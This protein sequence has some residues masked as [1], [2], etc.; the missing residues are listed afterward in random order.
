MLNYPRAASRGDE[1]LGVFLLS[2]WNGRVKA[3][4]MGGEVEAVDH[5][6]VVCVCGGGVGGGRQVG[7]FDAVRGVVVEEV[8]GGAVDDA[9]VGT[10]GV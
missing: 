6:L 8:E 2:L 4:E 3:H 7:D 10:E 5:A 9:G 1:F